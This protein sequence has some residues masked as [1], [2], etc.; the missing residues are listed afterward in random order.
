VATTEVGQ[1][2][3]KAIEHPGRFAI[4]AAGLTLVALLFAGAIST[5]DTKPREATLPSQIQS[6]SPRP[7]AIVPP[8]EQIVVDL[9]DDLTA[10]LSLCTP[11]QAVGDCTAI[12]AD[13]VEFLPGLGQ[14]TY[15]PGPGQEIE[16]YDP[17]VNR[18]IV[19]Y[20]LQSDPSKDN[21]VF[22]WSFTSK[23]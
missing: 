16:A 10:D 6:I 11:A 17:G 21:G 22:S 20:R 19:A 13:Q 9:R 18:V 1:P 14:L 15:R 7:G 23:S 2:R 3:R 4:V 8:Q 12:P 5:A